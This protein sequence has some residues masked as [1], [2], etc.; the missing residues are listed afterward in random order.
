VKYYLRRCTKNHEPERRAQNLCVGWFDAINYSRA[1]CKPNLLPLFNESCLIVNFQG[2]SNATT[3]TFEYLIQD[4]FAFN[5]VEGL[6]NS[7]SPFMFFAFGCWTSDF[8]RQSEDAIFV[9]DA[10]TEK[11]MKNPDGGACLTFASACADYINDN[12]RFNPFVTRA[13]FTHLQGFDTKGNPIPARLLAGEAMVT[14]LLRFG[15][16]S[17][18]QRHILLGD[19]GM[20]IDMGPPVLKVS[21]DGTPVG[22]SYV[23]TGSDTLAL[24]AEIKDEEAIMAVDLD[25]VED[26]VVTPVAADAYTVKAIVDTDFTRSRAYE[27]SYNHVPLLGEYSIEI[28]GEDYSGKSNGTEVRVETGSAVFYRDATELGQGD[29]LVFGQ[30]LR[31]LITRPVAVEESEIEALVD[32]VSA[33]GFDDYR[34][35]MTD[36]EGKEWEVSFRPALERGDHTVTVTVQGLAASRD[37]EYVPARVDVFAEDRCR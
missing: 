26:G 20:I 5:D 32:S 25:I 2:H 22:D 28:G 29:P 18:A 1:N 3:L 4:D 15:H 16:A 33:S 9:G 6:S 7:E 10:I 11:Y 21:A 31:I 17:Y 8:Q 34:V 37:F 13:I 30:K 24:V 27:V 35:E 12:E 23:Y 14:S 36:G 19:P